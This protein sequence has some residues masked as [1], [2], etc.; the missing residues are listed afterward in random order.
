[1]RPAGRACRRWAA[2]MNHPEV[3][4]LVLHREKLMVAGTDGQTLVVH[5]ADAGAAGAEAFVLLGALAA[6]SEPG[7][8]N[9]VR[10][11]QSV[12]RDRDLAANGQSDRDR[13]VAIAAGAPGGPVTEPDVHV[14][15]EARRD[16]AGPDVQHGPAS[17]ADRGPAVC[18]RADG[19]LPQRIAGVSAGGVLATGST[20]YWCPAPRSPGALRPARG[21]P[22]A[23]VRGP[24]VAGLPVGRSPGPGVA[25]GAGFAAAEAVTR[26]SPTA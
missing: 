1:M 25:R 17:T 6:S 8:P 22:G 12:P 24:P 23:G 4:E 21:R 19:P 20:A 7:L 13:R 11:A 2:R 15:H 18:R 10:R 9:R 16:G 14:R 5:H 26:R 3:G